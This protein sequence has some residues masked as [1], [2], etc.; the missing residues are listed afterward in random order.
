MGEIRVGHAAE[1]DAEHRKLVRVGGR[2]VVVFKHGEAFYAFENSCLHMGGP[3]GEGVILGKVE[4]VV[5]DDG[6]LL[7]ERFSE[8]EI[9]LV[10]PWHGWEYDIATGR[11]AGD[12]KR[13][14]MKFE[15]VQ[16][17]EDVYVVG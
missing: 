4:A 15:T 3:V 6:R 11:C 10:C 14:L 1:F 2:E 7:G 9:H 16:R 8:D 13:K 5:A 12:R 17:G